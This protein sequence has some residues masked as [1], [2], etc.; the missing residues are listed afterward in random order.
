MASFFPIFICKIKDVGHLNLIF[1][2]IDNDEYGC[3]MVQNIVI[4]VQLNEKKGLKQN[5]RDG[6]LH[7]LL[8]Q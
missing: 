2:C 7:I 1:S 6:L 5:L 4:C 3:L 8:D